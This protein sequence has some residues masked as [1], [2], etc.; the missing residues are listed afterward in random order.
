M[1]RAL[2]RLTLLLATALVLTGCSVTAPPAPQGGTGT[3]TETDAPSTGAAAATGELISGTGYT[4]NV[5]EDWGTPDQTPAGYNP[6]AFAVDL[7]DNDGFTDNV[8]VIISPAGT[9][10]A[11]QVEDLGVSELEDAGA[12]NVETR[13]RVDVAG[14]ESAHLTAQFSQSGSTYQ[15]DQYYPTHD[16]Q[17]YVVTFSFSTDVPEGDREELA[18]SVLA[19]WTWA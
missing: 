9:I 18:E 4:F 7:D 6:D 13:P 11:D 8:N 5:P 15:I 14:E 2:P 1:T 16:G 10:T 3:E 17:T 19:S 12:E